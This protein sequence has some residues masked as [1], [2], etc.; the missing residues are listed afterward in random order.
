MKH[1]ALVA[2]FYMNNEAHFLS[3]KNPWGYPCFLTKTSIIWNP[4]QGFLLY[5][6]SKF[7]HTHTRIETNLKLKFNENNWWVGISRAHK[8][9][10]YV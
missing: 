2:P 9:S 6:M 4:P 3:M 8:Y 5:V 7:G 1:V 10:Q